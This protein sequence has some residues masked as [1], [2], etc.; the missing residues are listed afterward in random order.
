[1]SKSPKM[2]EM[3]TSLILKMDLS[4]SLIKMLMTKMTKIILTMKKE[5]MAIIMEKIKTRL[6]MLILLENKLI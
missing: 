2:E 5:R 3:I 4:S 1:M 6:P